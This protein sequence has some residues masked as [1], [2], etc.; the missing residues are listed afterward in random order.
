MV[1]R[2]GSHKEELCKMQE[3]TRSFAQRVIDENRKLRS[4]L[5]PISKYLDELAS[6]SILHTR[7]YEPEK[8]EKENSA[9]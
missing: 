2:I 4:G 3:H 6:Q 8:N 1:Q 5:E 7:N 9:C